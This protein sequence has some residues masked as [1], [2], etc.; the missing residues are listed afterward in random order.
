M[1]R[2]ATFRASLRF[3]DSFRV[4]DV[5]LGAF[6]A[7]EFYTGSPPFAVNLGA[8]RTALD[9]ILPWAGAFAAYYSGIIPPL[10]LP[11]SAPRDALNRIRNSVEGT[12][13]WNSPAWTLSSRACA[14]P[15]SA[16]ASRWMTKAPA[17]SV[18]GWA[19]TIRSRTQS[20][21]AVRFVRAAVIDPWAYRF[22]MN[23]DHRFRIQRWWLHTG[24]VMCLSNP[25]PQTPIQ[26]LNS[27]CTPS[28]WTIC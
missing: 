26:R 16:V 15:C 5:G 4:I 9:R 17:P 21:V 24:W 25:S 7:N 8:R 3:V 2:L 6:G 18:Q 20:A 28:S 14:P 19:D 23:M 12:S 10:A 13:I 1:P 27:T 22:R 11:P